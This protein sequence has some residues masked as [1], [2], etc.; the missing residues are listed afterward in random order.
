MKPVTARIGSRGRRDRVGAP[1][2]RP[3][4]VE[5]LLRRDRAGAVVGLDAPSL[6]FLQRA[7]GNRAVVELATVQRD[8]TKTVAATA[9]YDR[10]HDAYWTLIGDIAKVN[11]KVAS[12]IRSD[13]L[14]ELSAGLTQ[15]G[16]PGEADA[17]ALADLERRLATIRKVV[18]ANVAE[19]RAYWKEV[20]ADYHT[21]QDALADRAGWHAEA[22]RLLNLR[23]KDSEN[24]V[25]FAWKYLTFD[26]TAG[27]GSMLANR[28]HE[29]WAR[30]QDEEEYR[31]RKQ[32][33]AKKLPQFTK[34]RIR[35]LAGGQLSAGPVGANVST[36]QLEEL[37]PH[38]RSGTITFAAEGL[39]AGL[40]A[41][42]IGP[43][44]WTDFT[45][46]DEMRLEDFEGAGR[47]T[48]AGAYLIYGGSYSV[49]TFFAGNKATVQ[50]KS[51][52]H[53]WGL[54]GGGETIV[55]VWTIRTT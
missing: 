32:E 47:M 13:W 8:D 1:P 45:T 39:A 18:D 24:Q 50:V 36:F 34:F 49:L 53:G 22:L 43:Q 30:H 46:S 23:A 12:G 28:T 52:G 51:W 33:E 14:A 26:D 40:K 42:A 48:S 11:G 44:S 37:G 25:F 29:R 3:R 9:Q 27:L 17:G 54:G 55:G 21:E 6:L 16:A 35:A 19:A 4:Q 38:G 5:P 41:G 31:R 15:L 10:V 7:V 2:V 20:L